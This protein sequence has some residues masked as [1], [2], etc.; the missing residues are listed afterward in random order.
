[1]FQLIMVSHFRGGRWTKPEVASFS[2]RWRD[3]DPALSPDGRRL[4]FAPN[5]PVKEGEP[6]RKDFDVLGGGARGLGL[7]HTAPRARGQRT[8]PLRAE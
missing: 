2:G 1:M 6:V 7:G 8:P 3:I 4:F 5:R